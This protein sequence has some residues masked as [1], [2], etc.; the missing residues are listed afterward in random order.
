[1][2]LGT[3]ASFGALS[4]AATGATG[5]VETVKRIVTGKA[6]VARKA[7]AASDQYAPKPIVAVVVKKK[8]PPARSG[9]RRCAG[10]H[11]GGGDRRAAVHRHLARSDRG[12]RARSDRPR[13][14]P[15][16][17]GRPRLGIDRRT[18]KSSGRWAAATRPIGVLRSEHA[19]KLARCQNRKP[20]PERTSSS[21]WSVRRTRSAAR[22]QRRSS[23]G[24]PGRSRSRPGRA[25]SS[26]SARSLPHAMRSR[27]RTTSGSTSRGIVRRWLE[28][29][30]LRDSD[31]VVGFEPVHVAAAVLEG[32]AP[33]ER[34]FLLRELVELLEQEDAPAERRARASG[35]GWR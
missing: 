23:S 19:T 5:T 29:G 22:S 28:P 13:R 20:E 11:A 9:Q 34:A 3:F 1:M 10:E 12:A 18:S 7:T 30:S 6:P 31:A 24:S 2:M 15:A 8:A 26:I 14:L 21:C 35:R 32:G 27:R 25:G 16:T 4:Y 33:T 17:A